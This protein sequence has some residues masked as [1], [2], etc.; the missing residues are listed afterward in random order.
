MEEEN[1]CYD[2]IVFGYMCVPSFGFLVRV[3]GLFRSIVSGRKIG[4]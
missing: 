3:M 1:K 2:D 4:V